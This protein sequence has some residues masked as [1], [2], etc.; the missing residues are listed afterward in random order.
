MALRCF[1]RFLRPFSHDSRAPVDF[2]DPPAVARFWACFGA[3]L[4]CSVDALVLVCVLAR[5]FALFWRFVGF[6]GCLP[7]GAAF[8]VF[9]GYF[10]RILARS[11]WRGFLPSVFACFTPC[12]A[13]LRPRASAVAVRSSRSGCPFVRAGWRRGFARARVLIYTRTGVHACP[14]CAYARP[15]TRAPAHTRARVCM[16]VCMRVY[17]IRGYVGGCCR[18]L[19]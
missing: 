5:L 12:G 9:W 8:V 10:R 14:L 3:C 15:Y 2:P 7:D 11:V 4:R 13:S 19:L 1:T 17:M 18:R 16:R 6:V